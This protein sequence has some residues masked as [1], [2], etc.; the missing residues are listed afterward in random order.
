MVVVAVV[1]VCVCVCVYITHFRAQQLAVVVDGDTLKWLLKP[2][3]ALS[4]RFYELLHRSAAVVCCRT[5]PRQKARVVGCVRCCLVHH[6]RTYTHTHVSLLFLV[7]LAFDVSLRLNRLVR[8]HNEKDM[9]LAI[10]DGANDVNMIQ[11]AHVGVG[12]VGKDGTQA[13]RSSDYAI[14]Q[15]SHL[16]KLIGVHGRWNYMRNSTIVQYWIY[17][18]VAFIF[19]LWFYGFWCGWSG[20]A[21]Y[22][23]WVLTLYNVFF[24]SLPP[25][26]FA[27][28]EQVSSRFGKCVYWQYLFFFFP[29]FLKSNCRIG[30]FGVGGLV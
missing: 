3:M 12:I 15:F 28:F 13:A 20:E 25:L 16:Q 10:G 1:C 21:Y 23:A 22:D 26:F 4:D 11:R 18:N 24:T 7:F 8:A 5:G 2:K 30:S 17:K 6:S 29:P 27:F 9:T 14:R 19:A